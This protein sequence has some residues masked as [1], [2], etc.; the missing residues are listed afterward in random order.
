MSVLNVSSDYEW[1][2]GLPGFGVVGEL[3]LVLLVLLDGPV[4]HLVDRTGREE[5]RTVASGEHTED[6]PPETLP[7]VVG[8]GHQ[9]ESETF[10]DAT[11]LRRVDVFTWVF[12]L[13]FMGFLAEAGELLMA[14]QVHEF[15]DLVYESSYRP[16]TDKD[17][18]CTVRVSRICPMVEYLEATQQP[19]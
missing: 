14:H 2:H 8:T 1:E 9:A 17:E 12:N 5:V 16:E 3:F 6:H 4:Q 10:G 13:L 19:E 15:T 7:E 11:D 18:D